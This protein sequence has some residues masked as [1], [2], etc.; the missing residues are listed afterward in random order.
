MVLDTLTLQKSA[1]NDDTIGHNIL[2]SHSLPTG[3]HW[4][5]IGVGALLLYA[6]LFN[7]LVTMALLYLNRKFKQ[8][9]VCFYVFIFVLYDL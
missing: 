4:Y 9:F 1:V 2:H 6:I 7:G 8:R 5:W 3:D